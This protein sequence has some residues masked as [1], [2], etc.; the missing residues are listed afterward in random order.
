MRRHIMPP[1]RES[2]VNVTPLIDVVMC[3]IIFF[4]LV[5]KIGVDTGADPTIAIPTSMLGQDLHDMGNMLLLNVV[6][7]PEGIPDAQPIVTALV[8][9]QVQQI[10]LR[11]TGPD[12]QPLNPLRDTLA[13]FR[14][15]DPSRGIARNDNFKVI[16]RGDKSLNYRFLAP[17]LVE[18]NLAHVPSFAI[19]TKVP[20]AE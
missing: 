12:G 7:G 18:C 16:I 15:G 20:D 11:D 19:D 14:E 1:I 6:N 8:G 5:A 4:M 3:L 9:G 17:V 13:Y 2:A 10:K